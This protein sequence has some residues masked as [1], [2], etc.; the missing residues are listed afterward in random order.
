MYCL[1]FFNLTMECIFIIYLFFISP[2]L[3]F[4][5]LYSVVTQLYIHV[6]ILFS[7]VLM[8]HRK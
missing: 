2:I 7:H 4:F 8:L 6:Y 5:L 3:N 1:S